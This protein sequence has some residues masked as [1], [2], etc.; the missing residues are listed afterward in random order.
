VLDTSLEHRNSMMKYNK[1]IHI[2]NINSKYSIIITPCVFLYHTLLSIDYS[3]GVCGNNKLSK[4]IYLKNNVN[5]YIKLKKYF[6]ISQN[7]FEFKNYLKNDKDI[8]Y[9]AEIIING[10]RNHNINIYNKDKSILN[11]LYVER[12]D[13]SP[14]NNTGYL[15][16]H[17][18]LPIYNR[19]FV[20]LYNKNN[21]KMYINNSLINNK[22]IKIKLKKEALYFK[23]YY[24]I[25]VNCFYMLLLYFLYYLVKYFID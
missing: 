6:L 1:E 12:S 9:D 24:K 23:Y 3:F 17:Q 2:L 18:D 7:E 21:K 22:F 25:F 5:F 16:I 19:I 8:Y 10:I 14:I 4:D 13:Y 20:V 15:N 11:K